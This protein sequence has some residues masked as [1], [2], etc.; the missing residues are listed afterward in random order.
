[1]AVIGTLQFAGLIVNSACLRGR[2]VLTNGLERML[3]YNPVTGALLPLVM[4]PFRGTIALTSPA[5][6]V[7]TGTY[8]YRIVP[9][10]QNE[11]EEG[12][13]YPDADAPAAFSITV[14]GRTIR[15]NRAALLR[16]DPEVTHWRIYR[17][18]TDMGGT[19]PA[20][21]RVA[22]VPWA[23]TVYNDN[24]AETALD[25]INEVMDY[26]IR[27][28]T[29]KPFICQHG[30]RLFGI[31]DIPYS[32]GQ[33]RVTNGSPYVTPV[34]D[35]EWGFHLE[36]K[37]FHAGTDA[38]VYNIE[39]WDATNT[40]L[41]LTENYTGTTG[42]VDYR[43]CGNPD[44]LIWTDPEYET[45]WPEANVRSVGGK[46]S[47]KPTGIMSDAGRLIVPKGRKV[48]SVYP[49]NE[50]WAYPYSRVSMV[51]R[52][53]GSIAHRTWIHVNEIPTG[54]AREGIVQVTS[55]GVRMVSGA[56]QD[57][58]KS[59]IALD[60]NGTL[61]MCFAVHYPAKRQYIVFVKT[62]DAVIGCDK[63]IVWHY[64]S[65]KFSVYRFL[66]EF[67]AGELVKGP[68]GTDTIVL[69]DVNGY[70]WEFGVGDIDGAP[71]G[72]TLSGTVKAY[73]QSMSPGC[74]IWDSHAVFPTVDLGLAGVPVYIYDGTG[75]GQWGIIT[76]NGSD[77]L[78]FQ[79]CF[80]T[81]LDATSKYYIGPI[82]ANYK[83]GWMDFGT[84]MRVKHAVNAELI[85]EVVDDSELTF[86]MYKDFAG[87]PPN[88]VDEKMVED[89]GQ[90]DM[91][92]VNGRTRVKLG[93][94]D[95]VHL[96]WEIEDL[97]PNNPFS[98]Y[99]VALN[100][101]VKEQ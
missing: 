84:V 71:A 72:S 93:G 100:V 92:K 17:V 35:A 91:G 57:W 37:E 99:D 16:D 49:A 60:D 41:V 22:T 24:I 59:E 64:D 43:I 82:L 80:D 79:E 52:Q 95:G 75:K 42:D 94:V 62:V 15:I 9:Y 11:D 61:Q 38:R 73:T 46:E 50:E 96:A 66:Q 7:L 67:S 101:E 5:A 85:F 1:M 69:G 13:A 18:R 45:R 48:Y 87:T 21:A 33:A 63:A 12:Q 51:S 10:N 78:Y 68:D 26:L 58:L 98:L 19:W 81:P 56:V 54:L 70:C 31:G 20:M 2:A 32:D 30:D 29:P 34:G 76:S 6:G 88:L 8:E 40:R 36:H 47:D 89:Y 28:P 83:T 14:A 77:T 3:K 25:F 90:I 55:G 44:E 53:Y 86:R 4:R 23:T 97:Q 74:V 65:N 39:S 27:V